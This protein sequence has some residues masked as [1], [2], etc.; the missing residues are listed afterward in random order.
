MNLSLLAFVFNCCFNSSLYTIFFTYVSNE[1]SLSSVLNSLSLIASADYCFFTYSLNSAKSSFREIYSLSYSL[2][3]RPSNFG[4]SFCSV[5]KSIIS[6]IILGRFVSMFSSL[7]NWQVCS[8]L[9][10]LSFISR[11][12][13][14]ILW[15]SKTTVLSFQACKNERMK[16]NLP[17]CEQVQSAQHNNSIY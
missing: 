5:Q 8:S 7:C 15:S 10:S 4:Y 14:W 12:S 16:I 9:M 13:N 1:K 3:T 11:S 17:I 2:L 6:R